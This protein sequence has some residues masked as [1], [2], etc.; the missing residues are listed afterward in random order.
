MSESILI[1]KSLKFSA[2]IIK[3]QR[4]LANE[5]LS[6]KKMLVSTLN[7]VKRNS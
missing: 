4:Y 5:C 6:I 3:L 7:T 2:K 1:Q